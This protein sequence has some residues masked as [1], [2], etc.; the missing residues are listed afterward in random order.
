VDHRPWR[1]RMF[2][3]SDFRS[4]AISI[5]GLFVCLCDLVLQLTL[6]DV[7]CTQ[8]KIN[9]PRACGGDGFCS[10]SLYNNLY[11]PIRH[12]CLWQLFDAQITNAMTSSLDGSEA[13]S[14]TPISQACVSEPVMTNN[15]ASRYYIS[16]VGPIALKPRTSL[17]VVFTPRLPQAHVASFFTDYFY[18]ARDEN[19]DLVDYP[20]YNH[21]MLSHSF[22]DEHIPKS[23]RKFDAYPPRNEQEFSWK[24]NTDHPR[25]A[26][27]P[28]YIHTDIPNAGFRFP[29]HS[30]PVMQVRIDHLGAIHRYGSKNVT[31]EL[32]LKYVIGRQHFAELIFFKFE[33]S[34]APY[35]VETGTEHVTWRTWQMPCSGRFANFD[36]HTH[37]QLLTEVWVL[38]ASDKQVLPH[39]LLAQQQQRWSKA[40]S[41]AAANTSI[42]QLQS[43]ILAF[44]ADHVACIHN[45]ASRSVI[46]RGGSTIQL[47]G[48]GTVNAACQTFVKQWQFAKN[49]F[50]TT[51]AFLSLS[52]VRFH[53]HTDLHAFAVLGTC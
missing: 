30:K 16:T 35:L 18:W 2:L 31:V 43:S 42:L 49:T 37:G 40:V 12:R 25:T 10:W 3:D 41:L 52:K 26:E 5:A 36:F 47:G 6:L 38:N 29:G 20:L 22:T 9:S 19:D 14:V 15:L 45:S 7:K 4:P 8:K 39:S 11:E 44:H 13:T 34:L 24:L 33:H 28:K 23:L 21:H 50:I 46:S 51:I 1:S 53:Q 48:L 27:A 32:G 17:Q